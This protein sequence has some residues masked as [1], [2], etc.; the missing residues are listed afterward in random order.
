M[1]E[2]IRAER[3]IGSARLCLPAV[4]VDARDGNGCRSVGGV[5]GSGISVA[6]VG[7]VGRRAGSL[8]EGSGLMICCQHFGQGP[9]MPAAAVGTVSVMWQ[10][11]QSKRISW[12][13]GI[14]GITAAG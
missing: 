8:R 1:P 13:A 5:G 3:R 2:K 14:S 4:G 6:W 10:A 9:S 11:G 7:A 12:A